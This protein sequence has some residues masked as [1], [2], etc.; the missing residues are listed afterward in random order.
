LSLPQHFPAVV[1]HKHHAVLQQLAEVK[2]MRFPVA[3][4]DR[5]ILGVEGMRSDPV[6]D[7]EGFDVV[8]GGVVVPRAAPLGIQ[9]AVV[10]T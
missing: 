7:K 2:L 10:I 3:F 5:L 6:Q 1:P 8:V 9:S 4:D